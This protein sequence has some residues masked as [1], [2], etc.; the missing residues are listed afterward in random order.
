VHAVEGV[1]ATVP[2]GQLDG[3][4]ARG[5]LAHPGAAVA[6]YG[7][8]RDVQRGYS[9]DQS[10][11]E[12]GTLPVVVDHGDDIPVGEGAYPVPDLLLLVGQEL[13]NE[14]VVGAKRSA[15]VGQQRLSF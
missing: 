14:V 12:L 3:H 4:E 11:G 15:N 1:Q 10:E 7:A 6:L 5:D 2:A 8:A 9:G 13:L